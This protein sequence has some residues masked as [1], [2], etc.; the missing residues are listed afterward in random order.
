MIVLGRSIEI[1]FPLPTPLPRL[2]G[3]VLAL[4]LGGMGLGL[5]VAAAGRFSSTGQKP[6]PWTPTP[7]I[8]NDGIYR[9]TRNPMYVGMALLQAALGLGVS[10]LWI[11]LMVPASAAAVYLTAIR[12]EENYLTEKFGEGY[13]SYKRTVRR[14]F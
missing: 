10:S 7:Q 12:P 13:L 11:V 9:Y 14:W 4:L 8:I 6:A 2:A 1:A 3:T 5:I